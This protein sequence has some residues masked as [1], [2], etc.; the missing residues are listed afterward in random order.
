[1]RQLT[2]LLAAFLI[3][4]LVVADEPKVEN[5]L[6]VD[7]LMVSVITPATN[8]LWGVEDPQSD[9]EWQP[10][11]DAAIAVIAAGTLV[12]EGG[13]GPRDAEWAR[14]A[15]WQ[16]FVATMNEAATDALNAARERDLD[17]LLTATEV[18]YPPCEECHIKFHPE[19]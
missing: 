9:A 19:M 14:S 17:A 2:M 16:A 10:L 5:P 4:A 8:T 7:E 6:T 3:A 15:E 12:A 13:A 1:M 11:E 18:M